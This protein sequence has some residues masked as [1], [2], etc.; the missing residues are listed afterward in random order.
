[1][2]TYSPVNTDAKPQL[3]EL[4]SSFITTTKARQDQAVPVDA[5]WW[6]ANQDALLTHWSAW[7]GS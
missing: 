4:T 2:T 1:L 7:L 5:T 6:A 3:D